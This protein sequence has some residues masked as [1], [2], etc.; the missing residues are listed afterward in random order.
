MKILF[1][2]I[3]FVVCTF[4]NVY[5][6]RIGILVFSGETR[7]MDA[8]EGIKDVL[9]EN[10]NDIS[11]TII[12]EGNAEAN[13]VKAME[14][15]K[16]FANTNLDLICSIGT[17]T[18][19]LV[20]KEIKNTPIVFSIVYD[21]I[22]AGIA[23]SWEHSG[24]NTTGVSSKVPI[25][26]IIENLQLVIPVKRMGVFYTPG[27]KNSE[28]LLRDLQEIQ[29][30]YKITILPIPIL[31]KNEIQQM[32][33]HILRTVDSLYVTGSNLVDSQ[34]NII[35]EASIK[36]QIVTITHLED[37]C[38]KGVLIGIFTSPYLSGRLA[39]EKTIQILNGANPSSIP[40]ESLSNY[41]IA[42]NMKTVKEGKFIIPPTF[43]D[44]AKKI[45]E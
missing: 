14:L 12:I 4:T 41:T 36:N 22:E 9:K 35:V 5:A 7:Y 43:I 23:K 29:E 8:I 37:L 44:I 32:L 39:G 13:K 42:I 2:I 21:P 45:E 1:L 11:H 25:N 30:Y 24:N 40:I 34:V 10:E 38:K 26:Y 19:L 6:K 27:E 33:P 15:I 20:S 31:Q 3:L 17:T 16:N 28:S 18:S